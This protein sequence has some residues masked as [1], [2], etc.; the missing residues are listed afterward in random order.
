MTLAV[1]A[2]GGNVDDVPLTFRQAA[3]M[4]S[5]EASASDLRLSR[6]Y[7]SAPMGVD[8]GARFFNAAMSLET[9]LQPEALLDRLQDVER[10]LGRVRSIHWGPRTLDLDLITFGDQVV[11]T[12]RLSVPHPHCWY[13]RFVLDPV[14]D[15]AADVRHPQFQM[16]FQQL[17]ERLLTRPLR[18]AVDGNDANR[19]SVS[20]LLKEFGD[21]ECVPWDE[22][23]HAA[24]TVVSFQNADPESAI[25]QRSESRRFQVAYRDGSQLEQFLRDVLTA[26]TDELEPMS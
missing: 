18:I 2:L 3:E 21:V 4:L 24:I 16:T 8:A 13:R 19:N 26:A 11:S 7:Q 22:A 25:Q 15:I 23:Q 17:R 6:I 9:T 14:C 10:R 5:S 12:E 1:V 20:R